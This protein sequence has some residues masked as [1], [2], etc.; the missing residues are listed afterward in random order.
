M[1]KQMALIVVLTMALRE[2]ISRHRVHLQVLA[3]GSSKWKDL[4]PDAGGFVNE[5]N[6]SSTPHKSIAAVLSDSSEE[7]EFLQGMNILSKPDS[8]GYI[9]ENQV[10]LSNGFNVP[11]PIVVRYSPPTFSVTIQYGNRG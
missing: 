3:S 11:P 6:K 1:R 8:Y 4:S 10:Q 7:D 9:I 2:V 5:Q